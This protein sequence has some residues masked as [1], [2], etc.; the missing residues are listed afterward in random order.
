MV[1]VEL[2]CGGEYSYDCLC[3]YLAYILRVGDIRK[4]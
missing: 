1:D 2:R 4:F 3:L